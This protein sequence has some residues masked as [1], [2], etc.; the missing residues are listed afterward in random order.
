[1]KTNKEENIIFTLLG[2]GIGYLIFKPTA[3]AQTPATQ[4]PTNQLQILTPVK[5]PLLISKQQTPPPTFKRR[6]R[7]LYINNK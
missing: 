7:K 3:P 4:Q 6:S 5:K 1:M 2:I